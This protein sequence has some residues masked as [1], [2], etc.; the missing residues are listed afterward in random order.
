MVVNY[1]V[2]GTATNGV[3]YAALSGT[4]TIPADRSK[5][6]IN[7]K[8]VNDKLYEGNETV[9]VTLAQ[10]PAYRVGTPYS[11]TLSLIDD[12][13]PTV[14]IT[15]SR[16]ITEGSTVNGKITLKRSGN[17]SEPLTVKYIM[18]STATN[19][20]DY[21]AL[22]GTATFAPGHSTVAIRVI[23]KDD[24]IK[25][26]PEEAVLTLAAESG[27]KIGVPDRASFM[28]FDND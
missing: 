3:D 5:A 28:I 19:G 20:V 23:P 15:Y 8:P 7:V 17:T 14:R 18:S 12:D 25:E 27:Y 4:R 6:V 10:N 22:P 1:I 11:A 26:G 13:L 16:D 21:S 9:T 24:S 2:S